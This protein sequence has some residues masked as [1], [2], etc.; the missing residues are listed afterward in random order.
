MLVDWEDVFPCGA[1]SR[2]RQPSV[3]KKLVPHPHG[4]S[5]QHAGFSS[6]MLPRA[7]LFLTFAPAHLLQPSP[8]TLCHRHI[9]AACTVATI[10][11][12]SIFTFLLC[13]MH[14]SPN[15]PPILRSLTPC[16]SPCFTSISMP[17]LSL[18]PPF[19]PNPPPC[20]PPYLCFSLFLSLSLSILLFLHVVQQSLFFP[21]L[22]LSRSLY[23]LCQS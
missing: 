7:S 20:A 12:H 8:P 21:F 17:S 15:L 11:F 1:S 9:T 18:C 3:G 22:S 14:A 2:R 23:I 13:C 19:P 10:Q 16:P 6:L 4:C 5:V